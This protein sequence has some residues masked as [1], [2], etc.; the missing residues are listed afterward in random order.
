MAVSHVSH[1]CSQIAREGELCFLCNF[2]M[3]QSPVEFKT[4]CESVFFFSDV[5]GLWV[6]HHSL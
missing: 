4:E 1:A 3:F 5:S 2:S 6:S